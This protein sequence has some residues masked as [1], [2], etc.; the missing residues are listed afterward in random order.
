MEKEKILKPLAALPEK[1]Y[2]KSNEIRLQALLFEVKAGKALPD[3]AETGGNNCF[4]RIARQIFCH[5]L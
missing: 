1:L 5:V 3:K 2:L 4:A